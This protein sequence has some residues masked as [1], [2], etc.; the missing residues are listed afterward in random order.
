MLQRVSAVSY[1]VFIVV[2]F[3]YS[4]G[5]T[6]ADQLAI[7]AFNALYWMLSFRIYD[8]AYENDDEEEAD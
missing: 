7:V 2:W 3:L 4:I 8:S 6:G 1:A 5:Q